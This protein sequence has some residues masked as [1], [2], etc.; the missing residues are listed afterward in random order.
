MTIILGYTWVMAYTTLITNPELS[1]HLNDPQWVIVD[2]RFSLTDLEYGRQNYFES[3]IPGSIYA[4]LNEDLSGPI[5]KGVTGRHPLPN[6]TQAKEIFT[7]WGIPSNGQVVVYDDMGGALAAARVWW[8]LR[9]LGFESVAVLDG[10]WQQWKQASLPVRGSAESRAAGTF[11]AKPRPDLVVGT[12]DVEK[13]RMDSTRRLLDAR[14]VDRFLGENETI[15]PIAGH[16]PGAVSAPYAGNLNPNGTFLPI[17]RLRERY[18]NI[19]G[20]IPAERTVVYCGS[21]VT[22]THD[23]L[24]MLHAGLGEACLYAGSWSEWIT[25]VRLPVAN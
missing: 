14:A 25:D 24:A 5:I 2:A 21:G 12:A 23:I 18:Q 6:V 8:M 13:I 9:W 17:E 22:S 7:Q 10:G 4:H 20:G 1:V 19:L 16:I 11:H 3:H 15:D